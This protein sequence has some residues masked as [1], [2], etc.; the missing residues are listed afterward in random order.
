M[1]KP[2][3]PL[4]KEQAIAYYTELSRRVQV[5]AYLELQHD[6]SY[7]ED[8]GTPESTT[9]E[10]LDNLE[11]WA[12]KQGLEFAWNNE[13]K[14]YSLEPIEPAGSGPEETTGTHPPNCRCSWC[15]GEDQ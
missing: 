10:S 7:P 9:L 4:T 11:T 8:D 14:T 3:Q 6:G 2:R 12:E 15:S 13:S 5:G 1:N